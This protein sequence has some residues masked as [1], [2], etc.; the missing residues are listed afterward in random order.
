MVEEG[1][2]EQRLRLNG[3]STEHCWREAVNAGGEQSADG[4]RL[5]MLAGEAATAAIGQDGAAGVRWLV[6]GR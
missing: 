5:S 2:F 6:L 4:E 1:Q 3:A